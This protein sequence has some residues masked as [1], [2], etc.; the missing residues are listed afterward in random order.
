MRETDK[1]QPSGLS[2]LTQEGERRNKY[3]LVPKRRFWSLRLVSA[4]KRKKR[5]NASVR[6]RKRKRKRKEEEKHAIPAD[7]S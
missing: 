7:F 6:R 2:F 5:R 1:L 4:H 3:F